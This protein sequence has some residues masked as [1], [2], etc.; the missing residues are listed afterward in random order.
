MKIEGA[1]A[2]HVDSAGIAFVRC[3]GNEKETDGKNKNKSVF[4]SNC[5]VV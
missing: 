3:Y 4:H 2:T 1:D 5:I